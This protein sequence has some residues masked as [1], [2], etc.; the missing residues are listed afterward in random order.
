MGHELTMAVSSTTLVQKQQNIF[1]RISLFWS[2]AL[3]GH[4]VQQSGGVHDWLCALVILGLVVTA[5]TSAILCLQSLVEYD[6][7]ST[8]SFTHPHSLLGWS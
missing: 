2:V 8:S 1:G 7:T 5:S 3:Q 6:V 4:P